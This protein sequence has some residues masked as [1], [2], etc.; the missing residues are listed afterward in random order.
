MASD[1]FLIPVMSVDPECLF[2][3]AKI[4]ISDQH[5]RLGI[6]TVE[7]LEYL[8][9]WLKISGFEDNDKEI[10][11]LEVAD[12]EVFGEPGQVEVLE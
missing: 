11:R 6:L 1:V 4:M 12:E 9:S 2:S 8:K 5:N 7:A 3:R 10:N